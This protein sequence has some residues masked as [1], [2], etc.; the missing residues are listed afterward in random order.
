MA[1]SENTRQKT[2]PKD[3]EIDLRQIWDVLSFNKYK[4][5]ASG[6]VG[7]LLALVYVLV[8]SPVYE[9]NALV[10]IE[11][12]KQNNILGDAQALLGGGGG[13]GSKSDAEINLA[14]SRMV[15]GRTVDEVKSDVVIAYKQIPI[16]GAV[17]S[18]KEVKAE[19][20]LRINVFSVPDDLYNKNLELV[21]Q[22][23]KKYTLIIPETKKFPE[24]RVEGGV[25]KLLSYKGLLLN[26][27]S[28]TAESGDGFTITKLSKLKAIDAI[29]G[30]LSIG[31]VGK[32]TGILTFNF[33]G[34]DKEKI[35]LLLNSVIK[36]YEHQNKEFEV[37]SA[38]RSLEF[39]DKQLPV[40]KDSLRQAEDLLNEF[41]HKNATLDL[42]LEAQSVMQN[43]TKIEAELTTV[44]TKE[45][46]ISELFTK[47][48]PNY[49][50]LI[51]QKKV[52]QK[53]KA[54]LVKRVA[55]M[56]QLQQDV[57]RLTRDVEI[58]QQVYMQLL[59]KQQEFSIMKAS[60]AGRVRIVDAAVTFEEPIKPKKPLIIMM[61]TAGFA[62]LA[63][64][65]F[66]IKSLFNRAIEGAEAFAS[67]GVDVLASIPLSL[68]QKSKDGLFLK[69]RTE[70]NARTDFLLAQNLPT[71][72]AVEAIRALRTS[73]YFTLME[74]KNNVLMVSGATSGVGKSFVST[75]LAVVMAQSAKKVLLVDSDM[76][77][78]YVH[79]MLHQPIGSG[80]SDVLS[81]AMSFNEAIR[82]TEIEGLDF[83]SR[84]DVPVNPAELLMK[85]NLETLLAEVSGRY[86]YVILDAPPIMAVTDAA[87]LGQQA[88]TT[89]IVA[90]YGL[91]T[92]Q[93]IENCVV[94]FANSNVVVKGAILNGVEK[95]ANNYY[96]YE[97]YN[98]YYK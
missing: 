20:A 21:Y 26:L 63:A 10:Q 31:D 30:G 44:D 73:L 88:G 94:R 78:G 87:I 66:I 9:A 19:E 81:G 80:L 84:G 85:A 23:N 83:V 2:Q 35:Q 28:I 32:D 33:V 27:Q 49:Q 56:P 39:I 1:N 13:G 97:A 22:G 5:I 3:D 55:S 79:E 60:N 18:N 89:I 93:D 8:A 70:K 58:E 72:P 15:L 11:S 98:S 92:E 17:L 75:N 40:T 62:A 59:N 57:I 25:G 71:D 86:D 51:E 12:N 47:D 38:G 90:R 42:S 36:N 65:Y 14:R 67:L 50:A 37:L 16:I 43:L 52:L 24:V 29:K 53:A 64:L 41:R 95:S 54:D 46:E 82:T 91:T 68:V 48:H 69:T 76:R 45:A 7:L 61:L 34:T 96:A 77:K 4:I 6:G 74:A